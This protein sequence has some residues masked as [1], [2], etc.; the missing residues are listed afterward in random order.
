MSTLL[1]WYID[2]TVEY[3]KGYCHL[4]LFLFSL[5][6][7]ILLIIPYTFYLLT[8]PLFEGPLSN[9]M[10]LLPKV[11]NIYEAFL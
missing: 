4:P 1:R 3:L 6:V 10:C 9:H 11:V 2:A 5:A 8:I 7:L